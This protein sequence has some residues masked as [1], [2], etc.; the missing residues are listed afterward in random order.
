MKF[1]HHISLTDS[2]YLMLQQKKARQ[3]VR[4][5]GFSPS[6]ALPPAPLL[7]LDWA[8]LPKG[9]QY[10]YLVIQGITMNNLRPRGSYFSCIEWADFHFLLFPFHDPLPSMLL[11]IP[12]K[13][14]KPKGTSIHG[15]CQV[16]LQAG[17]LKPC[18]VG[19]LMIKPKGLPG[20]IGGPWSCN[21]ALKT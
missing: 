15:Q 13:I 17:L 8:H 10:T 4:N 7:F 19:K 12:Q 18:D 5:S 2:S 1:L 6:L 16:G 20:V 11:L 21:L 14:W 9:G 3:K